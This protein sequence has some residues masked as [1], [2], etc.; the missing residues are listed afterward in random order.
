VIFI[1]LM[2]FVEVPHCDFITLEFVGGFS[3][4]GLGGDTPSLSF[5]SSWHWKYLV[6]ENSLFFWWMAD[7]LLMVVDDTFMPL[8]QSLDMC[9][10][11]ISCFIFFLEHFSDFV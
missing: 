11:D 4:D 6:G 2:E 10:L 3:F 9:M 5:F 8:D 7:G 1:T